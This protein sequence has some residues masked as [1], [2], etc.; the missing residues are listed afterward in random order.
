MSGNGPLFL[1]LA[2]LF[3]VAAF[4]AA[5]ETS[6]IRVRPTAVEVE[7]ERG[8]RKA[9]RLLRLLRDLP[10][11]LNAVLLAALLAQIGAATV[12]GVIAADLFGSLGV[13]IASVLLTLVLFVYGESIPKTFA[14]RHPLAVAK[15]VARPLAGLTWLLRPVVRLLVAFA[16]LQAP[17]RGVAGPGG[18]TEEELRTLAAQAAR[19]GEIS[20]ADL[21]LME[22]AFRFGDATVEHILV[23]RIDV[24]AVPSETPVARALEEA[25]AGGYRR[26]PVYESDPENITGVVLL[27]DLA[28]AVTEGQFVTTGGL[29]RPVL[30]VPETGRISELLR[31]MQ[32]ARTHFAV[33]V[34]EHGGM[35]GIVTIEDLV[36]EL[37]GGVVADEDEEPQ[38][39]I[40]RVGED[41]W[42]VDARAGA[43]DLCEAIGVEMP[44]GDL[45]SVGGLVLGLA[46]RIPKPGEVVEAEGCSLTV[47]AATRRRIRQIEVRRLDDRLR[48]SG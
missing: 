16:D 35:A 10:V 17:G 11:V 21:E 47:V 30:V 41:R 32:K 28:R 31:R 18:V 43:A 2:G 20:D 22:R 46:G 34:D 23:P 15:A 37:L 40:R 8:N 5:A 7:A 26:V 6:L 4:L 48:S 1:L 13:T 9:A 25:V 45:L 29:A 3:A 12:T 33:A 19:A 39:L 44:G 14:V 36:E 27:R 42:I 38:Q 24:F